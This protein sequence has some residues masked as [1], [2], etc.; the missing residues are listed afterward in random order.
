MEWM[1]LGVRLGWLVTVTTD[2][3]RDDLVSVITLS[4]RGGGEAAVGD[5]TS[6]LA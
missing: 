3:R 1:E 5:D 4:Q 2:R 6:Q